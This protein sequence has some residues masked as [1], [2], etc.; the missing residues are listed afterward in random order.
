LLVH[1]YYNGAVLS[2]EVLH[3][4]QRVE[5]KDVRHEKIEQMRIA[6]CG[7]CGG[8]CADEG[9]VEVDSC[10][11]KSEIG[12]RSKEK[13]L[14]KGSNAHQLRAHRLPLQ[15]SIFSRHHTPGLQPNDTGQCSNAEKMSQ[16]T[17]SN[18][19]GG[20]AL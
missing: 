1:G 12:L 9:C 7:G 19:I 5:G 3:S 10:T 17:E 2:C 15:Q 4:S 20:G 8:A 18:S 6:K 11:K 14:P 16:A 13:A